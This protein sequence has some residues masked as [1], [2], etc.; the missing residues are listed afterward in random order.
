MTLFALLEPAGGGGQ[1]QE[2]ARTFGV[3]WPHLTAQIISFGIVCALLYWLA[4]QPVLKMLD[5]RRR[6]IAQGLE[7]TE[8]INAQLASIERQRQEVL[9]GAQGE[10]TR[11]IAEARGAARRLSDQEAHRAKATAE[12]I[13]ARGREA[14]DQERRRMLADVRRE[15]THLVVRTT[16]AVAG[17]VLTDAD[18]RRLTAEATAVLS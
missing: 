9:I 15:A 14:A 2:L 6:Q 8:K 1:I 13:L 4:Y 18:Q 10:A 17:K 7:N 5:T 3:D 12:N 16:A 11:I